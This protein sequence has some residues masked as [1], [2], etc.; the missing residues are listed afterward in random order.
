M[1]LSQRSL[2]NEEAG[3][4]RGPR[5]ASRLPSTT[6]KSLDFQIDLPV[7][8]A[9]TALAV[10]PALNVLERWHNTSP[11]EPSPPDLQ[12]IHSTSLI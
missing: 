3:I 2:Q 1:L 12:I 5:T 8:A 4:E 7:V 9:T 6:R 11:T 10:V